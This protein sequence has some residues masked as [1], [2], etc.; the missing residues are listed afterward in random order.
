MRNLDATLKSFI[1]SNSEFVYAHLIKF[2][3][4]VKS[5]SADIDTD[6]LEYSY[7]TDASTN[8]ITNVEPFNGQTWYANKVKKIS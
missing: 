4:P 5:I 8:I 2:E 1:E 3:K 7:L 6:S